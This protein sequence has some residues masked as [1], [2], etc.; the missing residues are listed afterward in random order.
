MIPDIEIP[1]IVLIFGGSGPNRLILHSI[2]GSATLGT[3]IGI[4]ATMKLY[5]F[6]V[7]YFFRVDRAKVKSRCRLSLALVISVLAGAI[8]HVLLDFTNHLHNP[9]LWPFLDAEMTIS[10]IFVT[11]GE[12]FGYLWMQVI[13]GVLFL[14]ILLANRRNPVKALLVG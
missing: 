14:V 13:M 8:S 12:Q 5:P 9:I 6:L 1:F 3:A 11:M 7:S 10:P 4:I 2:L